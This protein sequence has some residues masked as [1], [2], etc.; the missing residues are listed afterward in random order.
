M[1]TPAKNSCAFCPTPAHYMSVLHIL[2][3]EMQLEAL[4]GNRVFFLK[5]NYRGNRG[6]TWANS[7]ELQRSAWIC[8]KLW[9]ACSLLWKLSASRRLRMKSKENAWTCH[10]PVSDFR[11]L[12][13][14]LVGVSRWLLTATKWPQIN[15]GLLEMPTPTSN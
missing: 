12:H 2:A 6:I 14:F 15:L 1:T 7:G 8:G 13:G 11:R 9:R 5:C 3:H 10:V 4:W